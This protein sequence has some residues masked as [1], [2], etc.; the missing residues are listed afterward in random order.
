MRAGIAVL[1]FVLAPLSTA[2]CYVPLTLPSNGVGTTGTV[3]RWNPARFPGGQVPYFVNPTR[4]PGASPIDPPSTT[5]AQLISA[6]RA[7]FSTWDTGGTSALGFVYAGTTGLTNAADLLN[8]VT[9]APEGFTFPPAFPGGVFPLITVAIAPGAV[10]LPGMT[11]DAEFAGE[12]V[13]VDIVVNPQGHFTVSDVGPPSNGASDLKG[14]LTHEIGHLHGLDHSCIAGTT[15]Y[16][17]FTL[18]GGFFQRTPEEDDVIGLG[19]LYPT[20]AFLDTRGTIAGTVLRDDGT[21]LFGAHVVAVDVLGHRVVTGAVTG[22]SRT[23]SDGMPAAFSDQSGDFRLVGLP[24][25]DY[26]LVVEPM[27]GPGLPFLGGVFG[28]SSGGESFVP[29]DF[30]PVLSPPVHVDSGQT[31]SG[32]ILSVPAKNGPAPNL[33][34]YSFSAVQDGL[35]Q[36]PAMAS[37]GSALMMSIGHGENI[38]SAGSLIPGTRFSFLGDDIQIGA[39]TVRSAD[40]LFPIEIISGAALGPRVLVVTSPSGTSVFP[41]ALSVVS[42]VRVNLATADPTRPAGDTV[43]ARVTVENVGPSATIDAFLG[44]LFPDGTTL[45]FVAEDGQW[46]FGN[47]G[48]PATFVPAFPAQPIPQNLSVLEVPVDMVLPA[49]LRPGSYNLFLAVTAPGV[50]ADGSF[51]PADLFGLGV[52]PLLVTP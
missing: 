29:T 7:A 17:Y 51:G 24:P 41:G 15:M 47:I 30:L 22:L 2:N 26:T 28:T 45:A 6:V 20:S 34:A 10:T 27:D 9:F 35:F 11:F 3:L 46:A 13:S 21:P 23:R 43:H 12:V 4:P 49:G 16:C 31:V 25:G 36:S 37:A 40:I 5:P 42:P 33:A 18:A 32:T 8:V 38:V 39:P 48:Q 50:F 19:S 44:L 52:V 14:I 1:L